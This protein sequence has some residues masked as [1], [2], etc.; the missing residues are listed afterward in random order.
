MA[1]FARRA[2]CNLG[3]HDRGLAVSTITGVHAARIREANAAHGEAKAKARAKAMLK[4]LWERERGATKV[5]PLMPSPVIETG[6]STFHTWLAV[7]PTR[8][9]LRD[10]QKSQRILEGVKTWPLDWMT[11]PGVICYERAA[12]RVANERTAPPTRSSYAAS[13]ISTSYLPRWLMRRTTMYC[14]HPGRRHD[15]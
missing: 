2:T 1:A 11:Y 3:L 5:V 14:Y 4:P 10:I 9:R 12:A 15:S 8:E 6:P 13:S 7:D